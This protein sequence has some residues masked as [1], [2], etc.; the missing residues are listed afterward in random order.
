MRKLNVLIILSFVSIQLLAQNVSQWRGINR[1]GTYHE[2]NL[3]KE[4]PEEGPERLWITEGIGAGHSSVSVAGD[5]LYITGMQEKNDVLT[6][7][8]MDGKVLWKKIIGPSWQGSY[9]ETRVTPTVD[10][11]KV[12]VI[13]GKGI[14]ACFNSENGD[15]IWSVD[16]YNKYEGY[17]TMWGVCESPL[18]V[19]DKIIYTPGGNI[20]TM[21]AMDK[22]TG[23]TI[24]KSESLN[25]STGY[26][27]PVLI[28]H[29]GRRLILSIIAN[30]FFGINP[31]NG[32]ILWKYKYYD[33]KH[34]QDH[35]YAPIINI[36]SPLYFDSKIYI[37]KGYDHLGAMF[38][39]NE[40]GSDINL[41]WTDSVLDVHLGGM[42]YVDGYIYGANWLHN[43]DGHWCCINWETGEK[44]YETK[45]NNKGSIIYAD[46]LLYC[47]DEKYGNVALVEPTPEEFKIISS[48]KVEEG[49]GPYWAH[50]VIVNGVLYLRHGDFLLAYKIKY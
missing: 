26:V 25:D 48:F 11:G 8:D 1:N 24:W 44:M 42:V 13:S 29:N 34:N 4:W 14:V 47:Y 23:E 36:N 39:L 10:N 43:R 9:P 15:K 49:R 16:G 41:V 20:T 45:W 27:S 2:S 31:D 3:L 6:S 12:Y 7:M 35:P 33:L 18:I 46:N 19:D 40:D 22:N 28:N 37:T 17:C 38:D 32:Q 50:P 5:R 30:Y 21:V